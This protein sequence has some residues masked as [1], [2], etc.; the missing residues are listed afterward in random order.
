[1]TPPAATQNLNA[2]LS[3][4]AKRSQAAS[5]D[6]NRFR[7]SAIQSYSP[8]VHILGTGRRTYSGGYRIDV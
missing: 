6:P 8:P 7:A 1:M 3:D 4:P 5:A 2:S